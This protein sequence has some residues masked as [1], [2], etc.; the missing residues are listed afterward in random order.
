MFDNFEVTLIRVEGLGN[1]SKSM[2]YISMNEDPIESISLKELEASQHTC[3]VPSKG[4]LRISI[5]DQTLLASLRFD[6]NIIK[7][8]GYHWLPLF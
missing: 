7:C 8:Q 3:T 5:E 1:I 4:E 6:I 2:C